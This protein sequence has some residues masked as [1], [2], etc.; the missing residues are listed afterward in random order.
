M[1][2]KPMCSRCGRTFTR[3]GARN[4]HYQAGK[5]KTLMSDINGAPMQTTLLVDPDE[6][7]LGVR[8]ENAYLT[9]YNNLAPP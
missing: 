2:A 4:T 6:A 1:V 5:C 8:T 9:P 3:I 7:G